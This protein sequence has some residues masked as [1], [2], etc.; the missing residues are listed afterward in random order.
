MLSNVKVLPYKNLRQH[1]PGNVT[2]NRRGDLHNITKTTQK[3]VR[4]TG[5]E[6][7]RRGAAFA[8]H[9]PRTGKGFS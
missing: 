9:S 4:G 7:P 6:V 8:Q 5:F 1:S 3:Q 2:E